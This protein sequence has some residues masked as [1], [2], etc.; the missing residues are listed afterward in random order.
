MAPK[1]LLL[2]LVLTFALA[3]MAFAAPK[4]VSTYAD[5]V[6]ALESGNQ[7]RIVAEYAKTK[8]IMDGKEEAAPNA[9]GGTQMESWE[10]FGRELSRDKREWISTSHTVLISH[11]R[12]GHV[13]NY[14]RFRIYEDGNVEVTARYLTVDK[15][16]VVMDEKFMG[17]IST[18]KDKEGIHFFIEP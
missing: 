12:Y 2:S 5:L 8:L 17:K 3:V 11:P 9:T 10:R 13:Y 15:Y 4:R 16:E 14:V 18:G 6:K 7:V 1:R